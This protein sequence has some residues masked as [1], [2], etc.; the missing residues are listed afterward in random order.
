MAEPTGDENLLARGRPVPHSAGDTPTISTVPP[1]WRARM[2][3]RVG[4]S[5]PIAAKYDIHYEVQ[6]GS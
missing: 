3:R 6:P 4:E 5:Q 2:S 1:E